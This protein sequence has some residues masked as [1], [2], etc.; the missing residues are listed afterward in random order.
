MCDHEWPDKN[1]ILN[2]F[3]L[4]PLELNTKELKTNLLSSNA[5]ACSIFEGWVR[6]HN[7]GKEVIALEYEAYD[8]LCQKEAEKVFQE[9]Q[10]KFRIINCACVHR[11]GRLEVGAIAVW[12]GVSAP[13]RDSAFKACRYIIDEIKTRLPIWKKEYYANGDSGWVGC[14]SDHCPVEGQRPTVYKGPQQDSFLSM[15]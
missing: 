12:V 7:E 1:N 3:Q 9:A 5:G 4:S 8:E 6:N 11:I 15:K 10:E 14:E 13:H 2:M